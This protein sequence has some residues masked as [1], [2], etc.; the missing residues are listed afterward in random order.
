MSGI[1][2]LHDNLVRRAN[3]GDM[4]LRA[5]ERFPHKEAVIDGERRVTFAEL[6]AWSNRVANGLVAR[7]FGLDDRL[8]LMSANRAE[9]LVV[10][11]ACAKI[12]VA[13]VP[14]NL[15]WGAAET[16]YV[17]S[18][19]RCTA[20][21]VEADHLE[22]LQATA[23]PQNFS[24]IVIDGT[25]E[26][27]FEVLTA[28]HSDVEP[29]CLVPNEA[30]V[31]ILYTSGTTSAPKGVVASHLGIVL[32]SLGTAVET[33]MTDADRIT[34]MM[35]LFHTAQLNAF[36]TPAVAVGASMVVM[37]AFDPKALLAL[38]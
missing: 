15:L 34:V 35:P 26:D 29:E 33:R 8:A 4:L 5:A 14:I 1:S 27:S 23:L 37:R 28:A 9:F 7:G 2:P 11:F 30:A 22:R 38:I 25:D 19:A 16:G 13:L 36:C 20:A 17:L 21:I 3:V 32:E 6:N 12:G 24:F 31:S 18:H 10:Y